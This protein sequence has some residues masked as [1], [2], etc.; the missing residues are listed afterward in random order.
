MADSGYEDRKRLTF[1]QAEGAAP[2]PSQLKLKEISKE[3]RALLWDVLYRSI[4]ASVTTEWINLR[5][6]IYILTEPWRSIA[7]AKFVYRDFNA[8]HAFN[9]DSAH[10]IGDI[11]T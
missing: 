3:L 2:L 10:F 4:S 6:T 8:A 5:T 7:Y 9:D 11:Q 1:E